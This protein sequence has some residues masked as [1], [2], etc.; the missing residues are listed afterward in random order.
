MVPTAKLCHMKLTV[1]IKYIEKLSFFS[2]YFKVKRELAGV[3]IF[4][5][6]PKAGTVCK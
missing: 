6:H 2:L 3:L 4:E 5:S 1:K